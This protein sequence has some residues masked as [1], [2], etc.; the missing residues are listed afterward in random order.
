[1]AGALTGFQC[2]PGVQDPALNPYHDLFKKTGPA[3]ICICRV[4]P[5]ET[6]GVISGVGELNQCCREKGGDVPLLIRQPE[7]LS[8][9][10][11]GVNRR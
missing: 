8:D 9:Q 4:F 11:P 1:L 6:N 10:Q 3:I 2:F 7:S 5:D